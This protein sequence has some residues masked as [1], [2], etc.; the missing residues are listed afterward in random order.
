MKYLYDTNIF[1]RHVV[2]DPDFTQYFTPDFL[3]DNQII[4]SQIVRIELLSYSQLSQTEEFVLQNL[5]N[6]FEVINLN[7]EIEN[8]TI[9]IRKK[10]K[11]KLAD[12]LIA[13]TAILEE[14]I[15]VTNNKKDFEKI[16]ELNIYKTN[17]ID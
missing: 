7:Y 17:K 12:A 3:I 11:L 6:E 16:R 2:N 1:I 15:L 14:A 10:Y 4:I 9:E 8:K 5:F 13:A